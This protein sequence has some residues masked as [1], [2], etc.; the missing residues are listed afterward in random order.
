M[1]SKIPFSKGSVV[2]FLGVK[3]RRNESSICLFPAI[4]LGR[5][6]WSIILS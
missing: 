4:L 1:P 3:K 5:T 6:C 2:G